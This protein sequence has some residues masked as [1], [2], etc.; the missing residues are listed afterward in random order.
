MEHKDEET[1]LQELYKGA[2]I[3]ANNC[4]ENIKDARRALHHATNRTDRK[5]YR[6]VIRYNRNQLREARNKLK[7]LKARSSTSWWLW[8]AAL[9]LSIVLMILIPGAPIYVVFAPVWI[10][11]LVGIIGMLF[12]VK[13]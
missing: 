10:L 9:I 2:L 12:M 8:L 4:R 5:V 1:D 13:R 3:Y 11:A 7:I 6:N